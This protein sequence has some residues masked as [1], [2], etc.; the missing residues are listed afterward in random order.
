VDVPP[1]GKAVVRL[2][3]QVDEAGPF[4]IDMAFWTVEPRVLRRV[5]FTIRGDAR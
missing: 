4:Q 1:Y 5:P 2:E 3:M